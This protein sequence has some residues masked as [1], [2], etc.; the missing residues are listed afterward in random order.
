[1][2]RD[3]DAGS[4]LRFVLRLV[5]VIETLQAKAAGRLKPSLGLLTD[6]PKLR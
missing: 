6:Q 3:E 2:F 4:Q 5:I 1:M